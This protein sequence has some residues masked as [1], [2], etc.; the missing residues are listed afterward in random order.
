LPERA[1]DPLGGGRIG[2]EV[3]LLPVIDAVAGAA[4]Q[5]PVRGTGTHDEDALDAPC[6]GGLARERLRDVGQRTLRDEREPAPRRG[7]NPGRAALGV[8]V[9]AARRVAERGR[10]VDHAVD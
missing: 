4:A 1:Q 9:G 2:P 3:E 8:H 10:V 6:E 5:V 7:Q